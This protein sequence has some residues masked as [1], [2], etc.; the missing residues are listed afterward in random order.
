MWYQKFDTFVLSLR[1]VR[2]KSNHCVYFKTENDRVL[3]ISLYVDDMLFI[4]N[5]KTMITNLK[6]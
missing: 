1:F 3:I 4:V 6:S 2:L 5:G